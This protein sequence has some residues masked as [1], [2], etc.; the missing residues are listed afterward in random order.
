MK[1]G[2]GAPKGEKQA[3]F[4]SGREPRKVTGWR[5]EFVYNHYDRLTG[6]AQAA[7]HRHGRFSDLK[8]HRR[9]LD[10]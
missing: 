1:I 2:T 3:T 4:G 8:D 10:G 6:K 7:R 5:D 9:S